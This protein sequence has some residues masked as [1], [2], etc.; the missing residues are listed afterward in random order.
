MYSNGSK[1][2]GVLKSCFMYCS[3]PGLQPDKAFAATFLN[4]FSVCR[5]TILF[6]IL[7][8]RSAESGVNLK[9]YLCANK[10]AAS[11]QKLFISKITLIKSLQESQSKSSM[12]KEL[13]LRVPSLQRYDSLFQSPCFPHLVTE[14]TMRGVIFELRWG[15]KKPQTIKSLGESCKDSPPE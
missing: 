7:I 12:Q 8:R 5:S 4:L 11:C 1:L 10:V 14:V 6:Q 3:C 2:L 13:C 15:G 9:V